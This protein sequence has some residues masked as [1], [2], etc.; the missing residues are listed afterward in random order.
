MTIKKFIIA[1]GNPTLL[2][3]DCSRG[4][5][6]KLINKFLDKG[7]D[8]IGFIAQKNYLPC[9]QM[10][11]N[12]LCINGTIAFASTLQTSGKLRTSGLDKEIEYQKSETTTLALQINY[13]RPDINIVNL[14]GIGF[15]ISDTK[16]FPNLKKLAIKYKLP[17]FGFIYYKNNQ[18][19][20][21]VYVKETNSLIEESACGS[22]SIAFNIFS[23]INKIV[24]P[25]DEI[26]TVEI[27]NKLTYI[28]AKVK[29]I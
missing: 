23:G 28:S 4:Q 6:K 24:Q 11:G 26:I 12:E 5:Q 13:S 17:A 10:M 18:I 16:D 1:G 25:T 22:G 29:E 7:V 19:F 20:P 21:T 3:W 27:R 2:G 9:L 14:E 8:Q 15:Y